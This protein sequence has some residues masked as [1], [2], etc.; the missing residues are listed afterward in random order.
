MVLEWTVGFMRGG[1]WCHWSFHHSK[2][3]AQSE[4]ARHIKEDPHID[5]IVVCGKRY[6]ELDVGDEN[7]MER[8][9]NKI[10]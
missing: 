8:I 5:W 2:V 6:S 3:A 7:I 4:V 10:G 9:L 1:K